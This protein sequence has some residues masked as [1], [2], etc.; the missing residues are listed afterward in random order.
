MAQ[1]SIL[2]G[3]LNGQSAS[4]VSNLGGGGEINNLLGY[5]GTTY[6]KELTAVKGVRL[7]G[8]AGGYYAGSLWG[9]WR[10]SSPITSV[11][12]VLSSGN[13]TATTTASLYGIP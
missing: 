4:G 9:S 3:Y 1:T 5:N 2:A 10:N 6:F 8:V 12:V 13:G 7:S 11:T